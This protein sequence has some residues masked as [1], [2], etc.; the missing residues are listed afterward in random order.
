MKT[1]NFYMILVF[2]AVSMVALW[3]L[4]SP[5]P[6]L[7]TIVTKTHSGLK[8]ASNIQ[9]KDQVL[10]VDPTYLRQLGL[11]ANRSTTDINVEAMTSKVAYSTDLE[12][13]I[14]ANPRTTSGL[15]VIASAVKPDH[16]EEAV[17]LMKSVH[18]LLS[19]YKL[20]MYDLGLSTTE[21]L[22]LA[23]YCNTTWSCEATLFQ[24]QMYPSH[25]K[26]LNIWSYR[27]ICIQEMLNKYGAVI[28]VDDGHYFVNDSL[29]TTLTN[30]KKYG[31]QGWAIKEPTSS[32]TH[33]N[34]FRFFNVDEGSYF[35][36]HAVESSH[37]AIYNSEK[38]ARHL[39][40][41]WV[42][43]ALLEECISPPGAQNTGCNYFRRPLYKYTGCHR[44]D[45][46][47][48]NIILGKT[49]GFEEEPY[50]SVDNVFASLLDDQL[51]AANKSRP[52]KTSLE[53]VN[54]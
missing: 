33:P 1:K 10:T 36:Q 13:V 41:P 24:F 47:A 54:T 12:S 23:K 5:T 43:C 16:F 7:Q 9:L 25:V 17:V 18:L 19:G 15:P 48:L 40:L 27:P 31:I 50:I 42:K 38:V 20:V 35:F 44:Y 28:W 53:M 37:L 26:Y 49:F 39:M 51:R 46:S 30:A 22:L 32:I 45:M 11:L 4:S 2:V 6:N 29:S 8:R 34:M 3:V 52:Y 21:Q 14:P